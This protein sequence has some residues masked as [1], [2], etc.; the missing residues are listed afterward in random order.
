M[1]V[2]LKA[3]GCRLNEAELE[4]WSHDF[5]A[6]GH[7]MVPDHEDADIVVLNTCAVT[8][9]AGKKSRKLM[10]RLYRENPESKLVVSGCY[11]TLEAD[12][13]AE[14]MGVDLVVPNPQKDKLPELVMD[15]FAG[16]VMPLV[17]ME[18]GESSLF[19]RGRQRA[20]IKIQDGCR[21]RCTFCIVTV[22]RG[23]EKSRTLADIIAEVQRLQEQGIQEIVLT[24]VHVGGYG[25]DLD[26]SL[27]ELVKAILSETDIPRIRFASVEPWDLPD[28]FFA[29]FENNRLLP[30]M[31]L[32]L[33]SGSDTVLRRMSRRCKTDSF[34]HLVEQARQSVPGFNVTS[35]IIVGFPG[36]TEEE[37]RQTMEYVESVGFGHLH[38]FSYSAREGTKAARLSNSVEEAVKKM[39]SLE[40]HQLA[41]RLKQDFASSQ[42]GQSVPV[43]WERQRIEGG[44][45]KY[46][47]YTPN[48]MK[49]ETSV[50]NT[51]LLENRIVDT[52]LSAYNAE[53]QSLTGIVE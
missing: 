33:Q 11:A 37:W 35:D 45:A 44:K 41:E 29:L 7:A 26:T 46:S 1:K 36:E 8:A 53:N 27:Y 24:G 20:F 48:F 14:H 51:V 49:V 50:S 42:L 22:A 38:I 34:R 31:H 28:E 19:A 10:N 13:V 21:Y 5:R 25:S 9:D 16:N 47:G 17:A 18:P 30:H 40:M 52:R 6:K 2:H 4:Q 23:E 3:L 12:K 15:K 39:R 43:L 32:P